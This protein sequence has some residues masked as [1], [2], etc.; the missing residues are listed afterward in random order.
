VLNK[1]TIE[2]L[3]TNQSG[4]DCDITNEK[5]EGNETKMY[6]SDDWVKFSLDLP[7]VDIPGG[8]GMYC[9]GN[10]IILGR[11]IEKQTKQPLTEFAHQTLFAPLGITKVKW[12]FKPDK[13]SAETFCQL[14]LRPRDLAKFGL[15]YLNKG[16]WN[17]NQII[18]SDWCA[19]SLKKHS[20][21]QGVDYGYQWWI[22]YIDAD[23][24]RYYG[25]AAQGNGGQK[26][27]I[28]EQQ[29][30]VTVVTGGNYNTQSPSDELIRKYILPAFNKK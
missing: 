23:G 4:L 22:K 8:K 20:V 5:A 13:S 16:N 26:I 14:N 10:S 9:T 19:Q 28:W 18:S 30:M 15:L 27:Y 3:L 11:I 24:V 25:K 29:N 2:N 7:M 12:Q 1:L 21:I 17:G 6:N